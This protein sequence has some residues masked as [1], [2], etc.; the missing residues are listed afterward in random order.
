MT[1]PPTDPTVMN[2]DLERLRTHRDALEDLVDRVNTADQAAGET[3]QP[4][5]FGLFGEGLAMLCSE[6]Q[7]EGTSMLSTASESAGEHHEKVGIWLRDFTNT[8]LD[9]A[10][11][12]ATEVITNG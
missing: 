11:L 12:F 8:E 9:V 6:A 1:N 7:A 4:M 3:I 2:V 5:A 10:S